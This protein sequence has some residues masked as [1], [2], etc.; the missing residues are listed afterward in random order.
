MSGAGTM[1]LVLGATGGCGATTLACALALA[2]VRA[3]RSTLL[4]ELDLDRGDLAGSLDVVPERTVADLLPVS[5]E[6]T[7]EH[8]RRAAYPHRSG[9]SVLLGPGRA[10]T[11]LAWPDSGLERLVGTAGAQTLCVVD[12]GTGLG[13]ASAAAARVARQVV[14]VAPGSVAGARRARRLAAVLG[15]GR[16]P[17]LVV[18]APR[19]SADEEL[20]PRALGLA[21]AIDL[22][23]E[24]P[25]SERE[26]AQ[27]VG[28]R[29]PT[30]RGR[31]VRSVEALAGALA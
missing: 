30:R 19:G 7:A 20:S 5:A 1:V 2:W 26:A 14:I 13:R 17:R 16:A 22:A 29:W 10:G 21:A 18:A 11:E 23:G 25:R 28:G 8:L 4:L 15:S 24:L 3:G 12:G 6:L 27:L 9:L 31:L